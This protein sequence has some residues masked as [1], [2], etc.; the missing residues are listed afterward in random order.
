[1]LRAAQ[2]DHV[3]ADQSDKGMRTERRGVLA[4]YGHVSPTNP[5]RRSTDD[6]TRLKLNARDALLLLVGCLGMYGVQLGTQYGLRSDIRDLKTSFDAAIS[7]QGTTNVSVQRQIDEW[8]AYSKLAYEKAVEN[9]D[10]ISELKGI[11]VGAGVL[12]ERTR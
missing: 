12:K 9:N 8:R 2:D 4:L 5:G 7:Q 6:A 10:K 11:M 3:S 1:M